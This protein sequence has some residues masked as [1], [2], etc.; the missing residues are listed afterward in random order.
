MVPV[1]QMG[2]ASPEVGLGKACEIAARDLPKL[3]C[4]D[5][6]TGM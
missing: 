2:I 4:P 5:V 6:A 3:G 1:N